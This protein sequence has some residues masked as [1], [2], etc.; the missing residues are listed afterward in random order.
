M[1]IRLQ[2]VKLTRLYH[3]N[4]RCELGGGFV[5]Q[6][7]PRARADVLIRESSGYTYPEEIEKKKIHQSTPSSR[8]RKFAK[9][10]EKKGVVPLCDGPNTVAVQQQTTALREASL[11]LYI[12]IY[13]G[14]QLP[15]RE[16]CTVSATAPPMPSLPTPA[17]L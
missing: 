8:H 10:D 13:I 2:S 7:D 16:R 12:Y 4:T 9:V 15:S 6:I 14:I 11:S 5:F 17:T 1:K 3:T